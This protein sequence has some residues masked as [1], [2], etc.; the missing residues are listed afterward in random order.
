MFSAVKSFLFK[1]PLWF[2]HEGYW[3]L[4]QVLRLG[5]FCWLLICAAAMLGA[6]IYYQDNETTG[7]GLGFLVGAIAALTTTHLLL[8]LI[9]WIIAGFTA[10]KKSA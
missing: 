2:T 1:R 5:P 7:I 4:A 9:V 3:R 10:G 6:S 8:R